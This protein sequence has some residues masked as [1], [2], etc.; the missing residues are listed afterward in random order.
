MIDC[1][2][3]PWTGGDPG[4][5]TLATLPPSSLHWYMHD[6]PSFAK[7]LLGI[8]SLP[9]HNGCSRPHGRARKPVL[10]NSSCPGA[11]ALAEA[12]QKPQQ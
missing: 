7:S 5:L 4:S 6:Q 3:A 12:G 2:G 8:A 11:C 1:G 9:P 10:S